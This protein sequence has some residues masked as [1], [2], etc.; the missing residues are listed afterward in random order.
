[1]LSKCISK[2]HGAFAPDRSIFDN[3]LIGHELFHDFKRKKGNRGAVGIKLDLEKAYDLLDWR[4]IRGCLAQFGLSTDWCDRIM[5]SVSSTSF[6]LLIN[7]SPFGHFSASTGIR[8]GDPLLLI[9]LSCAWS[10][11]LGTSIFMLR[12]L[13]L[14]WVCSLP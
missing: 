10:L 7:G 13:S 1:M 11:L 2:K 8:Q 9:F 5:N 6:S 4:F 3:I 12:I 14:M